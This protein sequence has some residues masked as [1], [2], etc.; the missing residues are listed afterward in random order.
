MLKNPKAITDHISLSPSSRNIS[1]NIQINQPGQYLWPNNSRWWQG[2]QKKHLTKM[3][4]CVAQYVSAVRICSFVQ[5]HFDCRKRWVVIK[6]LPLWSS[7]T[8]N[9]STQLYNHTCQRLQMKTRG[10]K[11]AI[12]PVWGNQPPLGPKNYGQAW[13]HHSVIWQD[14]FLSSLTDWTRFILLLTE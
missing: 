3:H 14:F 6:T 8:P 10:Y 7:V 1:V 4:L 5:Q 2:F 9:T 13:Q 12:T 11:Y